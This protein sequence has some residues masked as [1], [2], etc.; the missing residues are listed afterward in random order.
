MARQC[1]YDGCTEK[2]TEVV[3]SGRAEF[4]VCGEHAVI[5]TLSGG[6]FRE[7]RDGR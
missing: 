7:Q 3:A 2:A 4:D 1:A 6:V 5:M